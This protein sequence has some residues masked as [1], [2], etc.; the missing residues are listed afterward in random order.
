MQDI[1]KIALVTGANQGLGYALVKELAAQL[2]PQDTVY[3][4]ARS[5]YRGEEAVHKLGDTSAKVNFVQLDVTKSHSIA[6][7]AKTLDEAGGV[8]IVVS[9]AAARIVPSRPAR[10]QVRTFIE[11]NNH[12]S[13]NL[14]GALEPL[15]NNNARYV[16]VASSCGQLG[17]LPKDITRP[18]FNPSRLSLDKLEE[19]MEGYVADVENGSIKSSGWPGYPEEFEN[20]K[21]KPTGWPKLINTPSKAGQVVMARIA[22]RDIA[23]KRPNDGI[24]IYAVC[25]GLMDT[26]ASRPWFDDMSGAKKPDEAAQ[27]IVDLLL[28]SYTQIPSGALVCDGK[29][30]HLVQD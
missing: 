29:E 9:N 17:N 5:K 25:P 15:L 18:K 27:P 12:G 8:D 14:F 22:A 7:L 1:P 19:I 13:R 20:A 24:L 16:M 10:E 28:S 30:L 11:T 4:A 3:L 21:T 6:A 2:A 26:E 23:D